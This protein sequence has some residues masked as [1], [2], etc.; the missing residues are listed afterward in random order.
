MQACMFR[1][2]QQP[3]Q[4]LAFK[5]RRLA[6]ATPLSSVLR[7][8]TAL[9]KLNGRLTD[10]MERYL[11]SRNTQVQKHA[12]LLN[13]VSPL[14]TLARG[15]SITSHQGDILQS[16]EQVAEGDEIV[17]RLKTGQVHSVVQKIEP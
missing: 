11:V 2:I 10:T 16:T 8:D 13:S 5:Q 15:Y 4:M 7:S 1:N 3:A 9:R 14:A 12:Q 6:A 17:T